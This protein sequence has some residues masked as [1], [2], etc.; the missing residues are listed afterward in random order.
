VDTLRAFVDREQP[1]FLRELGEWLRIPSVSSL[2]RHAEDMSRSA[3]C[4][5]DMLRRLE[6]DE[7]AV[8][9]TQGHPAVHARWLRAP[10]KPTVLV[11]GHHDVQP[12]DPLDA[13]TSPP[14]EPAV[15]DGRLFARGSTDDKGQVHMHLKAVEACLACSGALPVNVTLLVEGEEE[16]GSEHLLALFEAHSREL[17]GDCICVSDTDMFRPGLP[18]ICVSTRGLAYFEVSVRTARGDLHSGSFGGAVLNAAGVLARLLASLQHEDGRV[19]IE[20][21]YDDVRPVGDRER[22]QV[23]RLPF[24]PEVFRDQA[25]GAPPHGEPGFSPLERLWLRPSLDLNGLTGGFQGA[26]SKTVIPA[27]AS[28]KLSF[29]LVADQDPARVARLLREHLERRC[30]PGAEIGITSLHAGLPYR[31]PADAPVFGAARRALE[32]AFG[33]PAVLVGEGGSIPFVRE[34]TDVTHTPCLLVGFGLPEGNAHA[35]DEWL[36]LDSYRTGTE[37][38]AYLYEEIGRL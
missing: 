29:R 12:V 6:P 32:R 17:K 14:F 34:I 33:R 20:G 23:A 7:V 13:W 35:P 9:P 5:A 4:L 26:G 37:S 2:P 31:A 10:G 38:L 36:A 21:F 1:R 11:Y 18:S 16:I 27:E 8:W 25:A 28:A 24:D 22:E 3:Q 15:R 30:P 19:A